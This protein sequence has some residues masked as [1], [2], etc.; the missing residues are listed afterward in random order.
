MYSQHY[1][2]VQIESA[3]EDDLNAIT[4]EIKPLQGKKVLDVGCGGGVLSEVS[5]VWLAKAI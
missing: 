2:V 1:F 3:F 4:D 5:D